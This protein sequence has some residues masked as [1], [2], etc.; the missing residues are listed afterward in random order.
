LKI[1]NALEL[2]INNGD[3]KTPEIDTG[4]KAKLTYLKD[5]AEA[6]NLLI[7]INNHTRAFIKAVEGKGPINQYGSIY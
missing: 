1:R 2:G 4:E 6:R 5:L 3:E 7:I